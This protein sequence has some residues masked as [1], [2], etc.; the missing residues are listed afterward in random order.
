MATAANACIASSSSFYF[1]YFWP[2]QRHIATTSVA[3]HTRKMRC[4]FYAAAK[5]HEQQQKKKKQLK[6][7]W[8]WGIFCILYLSA[9]FR[10][11]K[12][13]NTIN[14]CIIDEQKKRMGKMCMCHRIA[15]SF[16][17]GEW[18]IYFKLYCRRPAHHCS[19]LNHHLKS[20][21]FAWSVKQEFFFF[22]FGLRESE[23]FSDASLSA[24]CAR[25]SYAAAKFTSK[26]APSS[27]VLQT[28]V[29]SNCVCLDSTSPHRDC[30]SSNFLLF[31]V[32]EDAQKKIITKIKNIR[33]RATCN[34]VRLCVCDNDVRYSIVFD[35]EIFSEHAEYGFSVAHSCCCW[36]KVATP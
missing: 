31:E 7:D 26:Q 8:K 16:V 2:S 21:Y 10:Q 18:I 29:D 4:I 12:R 17:A 34:F 24:R 33:L 28:L 25:V 15:D 27:A 13:S 9:F 36:W 30:L 22:L 1:S 35:T 11:R 20:K 14:C 6:N 32:D 5:R 19:L 3:T 23:N